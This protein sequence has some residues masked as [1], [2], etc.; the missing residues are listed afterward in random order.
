MESIYIEVREGD[1]LKFPADTLALKYAQDFYGADLAVYQKLSKSGR[2][3]ASLPRIDGFKLV[4]TA[5]VLAVDRVLFVGV[6]PLH[7][8]GYQ[9]IREFGRRALT[10]LAGQVP[11]VEH[12]ALTIHGAGYGLD[13]LEAFES[14]LAGVVDAIV[15]RDCPANL[16]RV[17]FVERNKGRAERLR[18][19]LAE[20]FPR[21]ASVTWRR[22]GAI[23][24]NAPERRVQLRG[25]AACLRRH[26][27]R[28][29]HG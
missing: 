19:A 25:K 11:Q 6:A 12:L 7:Q 5:G 17:S 15:T 16:R 28:R 24:G 23:Q 14:E 18:E 10:A 29:V 8:F 4:D 13:E 9:E 27:F 3:P 26:A 1:V 2:Q 20:I 21:G 22:G